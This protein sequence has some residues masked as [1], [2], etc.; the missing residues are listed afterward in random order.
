LGG[1]SLTPV[2]RQTA[3]LTPISVQRSKPLADTASARVEIGARSQLDPLR[4]GHLDGL[5]GLYA[6]VNG[7][8]LACAGTATI[9]L[10][11]SKELFALG[12]AFLARKGRLQ[13][14]IVE[15]LHRRRRQA[16]A[17]YLADA[18]SCAGRQFTVERADK[19][20]MSSVDDIFDWITE[21]LQQ[22]KPVLIP[23]MGALNHLTVISGISDKRL[24]LFDSGGLHFVQRA[25]CGLK[26]G[27]HQVQVK[28]LM[29]IAATAS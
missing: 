6:I 19:A 9:P 22:N 18:A 5:C 1:A 27:Y 10:R 13:K 2:E 24:F 21:S 15:G 3:L 11:Q 28:G 8:R 26:S 16:L 7:L 23:L 25:G 29:R 4:Q 20:E 12:L 14:A 17:H